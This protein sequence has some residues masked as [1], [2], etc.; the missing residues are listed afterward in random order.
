MHAC[1][2]RRAA[3]N[4]ARMDRYAANA[5]D[6]PFWLPSGIRRMRA[7]CM[8]LSLSRLSPL[9]PAR[10]SYP[11]ASTPAPDSVGRPRLRDKGASNR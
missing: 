4:A 9:S 1:L 5:G 7:F 11:V 8:L 3:A 6:T 2:A 10:S